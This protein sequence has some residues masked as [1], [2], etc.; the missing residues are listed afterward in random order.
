[1]GLLANFKTLITSESAVYDT[2]MPDDPI[3]SCCVYNFFGDD[4]VIIHNSNSIFK[5][6]LVVRIRD[7]SKPAG[8]LRVDE[9]V[10]T[11]NGIT[12]TTVNEQTFLS[13]WM[14]GNPEFINKD[15]HNSWIWEITFKINV[16]NN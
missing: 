15:S 13:I 1:M 4:Q 10:N 6:Y 3:N 2:E 12:N 14:V 8:L 7:S 16:K 9:I 11:L 5:P